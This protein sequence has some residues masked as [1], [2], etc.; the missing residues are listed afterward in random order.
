MWS[1]AQR[2]GVSLE[3]L[4]AANPTIKHPELIFPGQKICIPPKISGK[5]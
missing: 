1:I 4:L 5:G 3:A 2:H